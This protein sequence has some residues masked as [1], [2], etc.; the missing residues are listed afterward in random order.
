M[1][2]KTEVTSKKG[3]FAN[4]V[5]ELKKVVWPTPSQ[6]VKSTG[7][8]IL[9]VIIITAILVLLNYVFETLNIQYWKL[10]S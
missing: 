2:E 8:V 1:P 9:F 7:T 3:F 6:T 4:M 5:A 10:F